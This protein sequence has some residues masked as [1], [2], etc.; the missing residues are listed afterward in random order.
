MT[1]KISKRPFVL[2]LTGSLLSGKSCALAAFAA[3]GALTLSADELAHEALRSRPVQKI[4]REEFGACDAP[5]LAAQVFKNARRRSRL[6]SIIHP[7]VLKK[8]RARLAK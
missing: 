6:E 2:G 1:K 7:L 4:L 5:S 8:A 3:E